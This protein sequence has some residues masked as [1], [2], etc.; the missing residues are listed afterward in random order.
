MGTPPFAPYRLSVQHPD[1]PERVICGRLMLPAD[2]R[3]P[4]FAP[5][6]ET[7]IAEHTDYQ[8]AGGVGNRRFRASDGAELRL[9]RVAS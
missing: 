4:W 7:Y 1:S 6:A 2:E 9:E 3:D 8:L 5:L